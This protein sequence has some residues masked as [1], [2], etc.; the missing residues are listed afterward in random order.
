[1]SLAVLGF[2]PA[3]GQEDSVATLFSLSLT[4]VAAGAQL[5]IPGIKRGLMLIN[6]AAMTL[7]IGPLSSKITRP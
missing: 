3:V 5:C 2:T 7:Q 6:M 4:I 1:M